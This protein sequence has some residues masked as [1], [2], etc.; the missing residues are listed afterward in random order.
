M[1]AES[2]YEHENWFGFSRELATVFL[3]NRIS[4]EFG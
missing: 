1:D 2:V 4:M 3:T